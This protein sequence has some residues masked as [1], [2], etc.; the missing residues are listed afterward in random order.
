VLD[1]AFGDELWRSVVPFLC[2]FSFLFPPSRRSLIVF[3]AHRPTGVYR[4]FL[5]ITRLLFLSSTRQRRICPTRGGLIPSC[6]PFIP[7]RAV[8]DSLFMKRE[9]IIG[10]RRLAALI[11][12]ARQ[13]QAMGPPPLHDSCFA[14]AYPHLTFHTLPFSLLTFVYAIVP[15]SR[16]RRLPFSRTGIIGRTDGA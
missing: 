13:G 4:R 5:H 14:L 6:L 7:C 10:V 2:S 9:S 11:S 12:G 15:V 1:V 8:V 3:I 16:D